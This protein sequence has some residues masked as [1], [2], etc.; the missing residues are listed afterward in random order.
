MTF[1]G[2]AQ[3]VIF[4]QMKLVSFGSDHPPTPENESVKNNTDVL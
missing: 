4:F 3:N 1:L 2:I